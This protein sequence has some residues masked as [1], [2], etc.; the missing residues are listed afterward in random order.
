LRA[1]GLGD[2]D[3]VAGLARAAE[4]RDATVYR[5]DGAQLLIAYR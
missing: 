2:E 1:F 3:L 5:E 4:L